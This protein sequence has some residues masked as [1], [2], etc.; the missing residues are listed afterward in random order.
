[1]RKLARPESPQPGV[2]R[3]PRL[4]R[5]VVGVVRRPQGR[6]GRPRAPP[7]MTGHERLEGRR[8][9]VAGPL[10]QLVVGHTGTRRPAAGLVG[11]LHRP[12]R[13]GLPVRLSVQVRLSPMLA[14]EQILALIRE[15]R[16]PSRH[17]CAS[18]PAP[19][20]SPRGAAGVPPPPQAA[21]RHRRLIETR[22]NRFGLPD[23][24]NLVVGRIDIHPAG[25]R[26]RPARSARSRASSGDIYIAGTNLNRRCTATAS[27]SASSACATRPRRRPDR[28]HPRARRTT[29]VGRFEVDD[30]ASA[31]SCRSTAG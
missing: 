12:G 16:R 22:G 6:D 2:D 28:P 7:V 25:L 27:S 18:C 1:M 4:L 11:N 14:D 15:Q 26:L 20:D 21:G 5:H 17:R 19:Q 23:R 10:D 13:D 29:V 3:D 8:L 24:M 30:R 9:A 31:S